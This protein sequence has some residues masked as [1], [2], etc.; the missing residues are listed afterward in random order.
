MNAERCAMKYALATRLR[1][2]NA[3]PRDEA[4]FREALRKSG[5]NFDELRDGWGRLLQVKASSTTRFTDRI[6]TVD[7]RQFDPNQTGHRVNLKPIMQ[8][9]HVLLLQSNGPD[10]KTGTA[11]VYNVAEGRYVK[12]DYNLTFA[13]MFPAD[14]PEVV[15]VVSLMK[16]ETG[17]TATYMAAPLFQAIGTELIANWERTPPRNPLAHVQ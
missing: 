1:E 7:R 17:S 11:D 10:G 15:M 13:G 8:T 6:A 4:S 12:G 3:F 5:I 9:I 14:E 16:P 2:G